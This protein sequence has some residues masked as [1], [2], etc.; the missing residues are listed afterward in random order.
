MGVENYHVIELVG[1]GSFGKVYKGRRKFSGQTVAMKFIPKHG[2]SEKDILNLRQEIEILRKL[3]HENIIAMLDSFES[4]QE[5]CVV[6][7]FAQGELFEIL[8]DEQVQAIAKQLVRALHYLHSNRIIHRDMKLQN[9]LIGAGSIVKL[10]DFGFARAMSANTVVLRSIKGTPLYMA[11]ELVRE[12][13]YNH[14]ADLWSLGVILKKIL[15]GC[16]SP[17]IVFTPLFLLMFLVNYTARFINASAEVCYVGCFCITALCNS[18]FLDCFC[19]QLLCKW[20]MTV[21]TNCQIRSQRCLS[22]RDALDEHFVINMDGVNVLG[23][24]YG[25]PGIIPVSPYPETCKLYPPTKWS[26]N[27]HTLL[28]YS[29][30]VLRTPVFTEAVLGEN[31]EGE[32]VKPPERSFWAK[33]WMYLIPLGLILMNAM[34]Q[35]MN[36]AEEPGNG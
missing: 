4:P 9:I 10:C 3:K 21:V 19:T 5:F 20:V 17:Q 36:M 24:N 22:Q 23:V 26:F 8:E 7:E 13:P 34:T 29:N 12:Q 15:M 1:E 11:P 16:V 27:S 31:G 32:E 33:Y 2:K 6:T 14:T 18:W 35:A 28:K 30:E 25:P